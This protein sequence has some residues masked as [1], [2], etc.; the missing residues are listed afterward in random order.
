ML[1]SQ[2][3]LPIRK[4]KIRKTSDSKEAAF[5]VPKNWLNFKIIEKS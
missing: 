4:L 1:L 2:L 5:C 3:N